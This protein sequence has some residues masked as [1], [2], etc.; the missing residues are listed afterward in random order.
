MIPGLSVSSIIGICLGLA[1]G[2][3]YWFGV[4]VE[5]KEHHCLQTRN[6]R[7]QHEDSAA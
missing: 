2:M 5:L 1:L 3:M 6:T 7:R 4:M